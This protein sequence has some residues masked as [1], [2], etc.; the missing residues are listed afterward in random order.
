MLLQKL[1]RKRCF[2]DDPQVET[3]PTSQLKNA[4]REAGTRHTSDKTNTD[5]RRQ[6]Q[7]RRRDHSAIFKE[8]SI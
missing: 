3:G 2:A 6:S 7:A 1:N 4:L 8:R 5:H